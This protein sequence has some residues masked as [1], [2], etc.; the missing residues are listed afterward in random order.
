MTQEPGR[1]ST[2]K[3]PGPAADPEAP[4][5]RL[6]VVGLIER[7]VG[8]D[9]G[10]SGRPGGS[11]ADASAAAGASEWLLLR[12]IGAEEVW[13]PPGGRLERGED[14]KAGALREVMEE[15]GL[16][17]R[18]AGPCYAYLT[19]HKHE[20]AIAVSMACRATSD[21]GT[22]I[23]E[24]EHAVDWRWVPGPEWE[25]LSTEG[26]SSWRPEDVTRATRLATTLWETRGE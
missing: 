18:V 19:Y 24:E 15:T 26:K 4:Y 10:A 22:I 11:A 16:A 12:H 13:D 7:R 1:E 3:Q 8:D 25:R 23:I 14:L 6:A 5:A 21:T 20:R 17:V 2:V 9:T